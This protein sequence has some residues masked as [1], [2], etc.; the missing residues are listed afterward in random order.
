MSNILL[1]ESIRR[2]ANKLPLEK[3]IQFAKMIYMEFPDAL[4]PKQTCTVLSVEKLSEPMLIK[5][6]NFITTNIKR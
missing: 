1:I 4:S 5:L 3:R 2:D 6:N